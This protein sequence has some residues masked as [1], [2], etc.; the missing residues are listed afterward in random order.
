MSYAEQKEYQ[1]LERDIAK[2]ER[3]KTALEQKFATEDWDGNEIDQQSRNLQG[4]IEQ[5][6]QKTERWFELSAKLEAQA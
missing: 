2:L 6:D 5:I 4:I 1:R 3:D